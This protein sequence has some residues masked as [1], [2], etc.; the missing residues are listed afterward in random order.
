[1]ALYSDAPLAKPFS[2][3]K[4]TLL[5]AWWITIF[6]TCLTLLRLAG[7]YIR[8]EKL[9]LEDKVAALS[10][11]PLY[12][13]IACVHVVLLYGTNNIRVDDVTLSQGELDRRATGSRVVMASRVFYT[14]A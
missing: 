3:A 14:A 12:M 1:M 13:R 5:V 7:R 6:C 9:F 10:L 2:D 11:V 8:V 4:P